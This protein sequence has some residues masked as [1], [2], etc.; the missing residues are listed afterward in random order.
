MGVDFTATKYN[1]LYVSEIYELIDSVDR[2]DRPAALRQLW[3]KTLEQVIYFT[4]SPEIKFYRS[5]APAYTPYKHNQDLAFV[6]METV[7]DKM[8][9]FL[10][11]HPKANPNLTD[12]KRDKL[13]VDFME[14]MGADEAEAMTNMF[15]RK[16]GCKAITKALVNK[17]APHFLAKG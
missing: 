4:Y 9:L 13:W 6:S 15:N 16:K 10:K 8:Y 1:N 11:D 12:K 17:V 7:L 2:K 14:T 3:N 5:K